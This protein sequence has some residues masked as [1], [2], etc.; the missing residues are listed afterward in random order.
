MSIKICKLSFYSRSLFIAYWRI[1]Y[2]ENPQ[3]GVSIPQNVKGYLRNQVLKILIHREN[4]ISYSQTHTQKIKLKDE[5]I[6][7]VTNI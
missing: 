3:R 2:K 1:I 5:E 6:F 7:K 4:I